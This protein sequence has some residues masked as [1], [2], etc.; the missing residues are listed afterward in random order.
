M[1]ENTQPTE[2]LTAE[3]KVEIL[4]NNL[5]SVLET[6]EFDNKPFSK[7]MLCLIKPCLI[8]LTAETV[9]DLQ[10]EVDKITFATMEPSD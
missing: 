6:F 5:I 4:F 10:E 9:G 1:E 7:G 8:I 2:K 3:M